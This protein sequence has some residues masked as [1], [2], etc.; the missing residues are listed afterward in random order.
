M[1]HAS[2][3]AGRWHTMPLVEQLGNVGSEV[4]RAARWAARDPAGSRRAFERALEL[5]DLTIADPRWRGRLK[6]LTRA[7]EL[8]C[9][10]ALTG[11]REFGSTL[12]DMERWFLPFAVAARRQMEEGRKR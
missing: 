10:A 6:E 4:G 1:L 12:E 8:L 7:R 2:L 5:L 3:A 9:D 11:G